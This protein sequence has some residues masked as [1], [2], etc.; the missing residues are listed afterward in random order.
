MVYKEKSHLEMDDVGVPPLME[1]PIYI[2]HNWG[3]AANPETAFHLI[4]LGWD[5]QLMDSD[6]PQYIL[7]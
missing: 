5:S 7:Q 1:T 6:Y 2:I 3:V 4:L